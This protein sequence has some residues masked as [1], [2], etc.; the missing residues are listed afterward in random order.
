MGEGR[1]GHEEEGRGGEVE[2]SRRTRV[3]TLPQNSGTGHHR[4]REHIRGGDPTLDLDH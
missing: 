4:V 2:G 1:S 3:V